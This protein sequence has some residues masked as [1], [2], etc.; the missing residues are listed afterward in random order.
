MSWLPGWG[1]R[2]PITIDHTKIDSDLTYFPVPLFLAPTV[3]GVFNKI[4]NDYKKIAIT[5]SDGL[6]QLYGEVEQWVY[7]EEPEQAGSVLEVGPGKTYSTINSAI[8]AASDEDSIHIYPGTYNE[9]VVWEKRVHLIGKGATSSDVTINGAYAIDCTGYSS[10]IYSTKYLFKNFRLTSPASWDRCIRNQDDGTLIKIICLNVN[11]DTQSSSYCIDY[12]NNPDSIRFELYYCHVKRGYSHFLN[13]SNSECLKIYKC[14]ADQTIHYYSSSAEAYTADY[15]I[16]Y[17]EHY[18]LEHSF[19][20]YMKGLVWTSKSD[21][22]VSSTEDT[23]I[24]LYYD[25]TK[26]DNGTYISAPGTSTAQ[27]VWTSKFLARYGM[28]QDPSVGGNSIIDSTNNSHHGA[29]GGSMAFDDLVD[30]TAGPAIDFDGSN[31]NIALPYGNVIITDY[32]NFGIIVWARLDSLNSQ[33]ITGNRLV[34]VDSDGDSRCIPGFGVSSNQKVGFSYYDGSFND[35]EGQDIVLGNYYSLAYKKI[36]TNHNLFLDGSKYPTTFTATPNADPGPYPVYIGK[37]YTG[38]SSRYWD[39]PIINVA[40]FNDLSDDWI[41]ADY[42]AQTNNLLN[43]GDKELPPVF[44]CEGSVIDAYTPMSGASVN[45]YLRSTGELV[46]STVTTSSG[47]FSMSS[48]YNDYHFAVAFYNDDT[49]NALIYDYLSPT[50][51]GGS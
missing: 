2:I 8:T 33:T 44:F 30:S 43:F 34:S 32:T 41:S 9:T 1:Y 48:Q 14:T 10:P 21:W 20:D 17:N 6:T 35:F 23:T 22:V 12:T 36:G 51:S 38:G 16:S 4:N 50:V 49:K 28:A 13:L 42:Y 31:D 15:V 25:S 5:K 40:L 27:N 39:G 29:P 37:D 26:S 3:S 46:D 18:G 19:A 7:E 45:L 24:Y 47:T 11:F